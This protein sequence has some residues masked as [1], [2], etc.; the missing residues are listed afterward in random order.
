MGRHFFVNA[1]DGPQLAFTTRIVNEA[2]GLTEGHLV[3]SRKLDTFFYHQLPM[4]QNREFTVYTSGNLPDDLR[5]LWDT[6]RLDADERTLFERRANAMLARYD[7]AFGAPAMLLSVASPRFSTTLPTNPGV[8]TLFLITAVTIVYLLLMAGIIERKLLD[9]SLTIHLTAKALRGTVPSASH[10]SDRHVEPAAEN[11][12]ER[13]VPDQ[14]LLDMAVFAAN[15]G[16]DR[17]VQCELLR[18]FADEA[19][20]NLDDCRDALAIEDAAALECNAH[21][22]KSAARTIGAEQLADACVAIES[23][24]REDDFREM[25]ALIERK[26]A[27]ISAL[28]AQIHAELAREAATEDDRVSTP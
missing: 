18:R 7:D 22:L 8:T 6:P 10:R 14:Q 5:A 20:R 9:K 25:T 16:D 2:T 3:V 17:T 27:L 24:T 19:K 4:L 26:A 23:A 12:A 28:D 11:R 15:I 13:S 21:K 1:G